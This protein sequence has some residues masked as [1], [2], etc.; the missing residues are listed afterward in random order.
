MIRR[1]TRWYRRRQ[2]FHQYREEL[3]EKYEGTIPRTGISTVLLYYEWLERNHPEEYEA[4]EARR[5]NR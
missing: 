3:N 1:I 5:L 4:L 2:A